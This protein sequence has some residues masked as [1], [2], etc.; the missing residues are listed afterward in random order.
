M[1][2][3]GGHSGLPPSKTVPSFGRKIG[4]D[5]IVKEWKEMPQKLRQA[6]ILS[7]RKISTLSKLMS[8]SPGRFPVT[9]EVIALC[10]FWMKYAHRGREY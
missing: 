9:L 7:S 4:R 6:S 2:G 10:H 1:P 5:F 3:K 8:G